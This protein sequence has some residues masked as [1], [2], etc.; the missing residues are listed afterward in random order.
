MLIIS[1]LIVGRIAAASWSNVLQKRAINDTRVLGERPTALEMLLA[2]WMLMVAV[3]APWWGSA[4]WQSLVTPFLQEQTDAPKWF[5]FWGWMTIACALEMPGNLLLLRSIQRTDLS[6]FGPLSSYKPIVGMLLGWW[7]L[8][9]I[10]TLLGAIGMGIVL[11]GSLLL[12]D[13]SRSNTKHGDMKTG[14]TKLGITD[15]GV[16]DRLLAVALTAA[17]S[18]FLK[19][20]MKHQ[21]TLTSLAVWSLVSWLL[22][23]AWLT[24]ESLKS[25]SNRI[26]TPRFMRVAIQP[27]VLGIAGSMI[28]MQWLT[29]AVFQMM[30]VGYALALFQLGS[31]VSVYLG[32]R[33]FGEVDFWRRMLAAS[34][35][36]VGASLIVLAG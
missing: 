1:L 15:P 32:H 22:A 14:V 16:R 34:I 17:G 28:V 10:P 8:A 24:L 2:I 5:A 12:T 4:V 13:R 25:R 31:L 33:L 7:I 29:I 3:L 30:H 6:I 11:G 19:L 26:A 20:A 36:F 23:L 9:E 27:N 18:I 21:G 35:M